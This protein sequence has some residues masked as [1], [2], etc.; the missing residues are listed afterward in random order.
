MIEVIFNFF[1]LLSIIKSIK[2]KVYKN[3]DNENG[4]SFQREMLYKGYNLN[5]AK[6]KV[7]NKIIYLLIPFLC[8]Q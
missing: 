3:N 7:I 4:V 6:N 2:V 1:E 8:N 5:N